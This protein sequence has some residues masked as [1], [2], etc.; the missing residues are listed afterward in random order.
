MSDSQER[1]AYAGDQLLQGFWRRAEELN[2]NS[3]TLQLVV[4]Q[5]MAT[6]ALYQ[7]WPGKE[8]EFLNG[9]IEAASAI[10]ASSSDEDIEAMK[11]AGNNPITDPTVAQV[12][13]RE[14]NDKF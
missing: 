13:R 12:V 4:S 11:R 9:F 5:I 6:M 2:V 10:I 3:T 8:R 14:I 1:Q 7:A